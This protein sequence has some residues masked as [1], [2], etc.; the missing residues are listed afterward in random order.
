MAKEQIYNTNVSEFSQGIDL[1]SSP[2]SQK[3][4]T[5][6]FAL[7]AV[8]ETRDGNYNF[9]S[10]ELSNYLT[11]SFSSGFYPIGDRYIGDDTGFVI[12]LNPTTGVVELG[13]LHKSGKWEIIVNT[14]ILGL[15]I[16]NQCDITFRIRK[17]NER[18]VYWTD[19]LNLARV[20]NIDRPENFY[21]TV[22]TDYLNNTGNP[23]TF[24]GERWD[25][26]SFNL[27]KTFSSTP[28]FNSLV[29]LETG[30]I[31]PGSYNFAIQLVDQDL[32][33]TGWIT[34]S[35]TTNVYNDSTSLPYERIRGSRNVTTDSQ[36]FPRT[37]KAIQLTIGNLDQSFPYYRVAII[38][39][40]GNTG[41]P[42]KVLVSELFSTFD[43]IFIYS[44]D[45]ADLTETPL[46][47][48]LIDNTVI[49]APQHIEQLENR[50]IL[51]NGKGKGKNWCDYQRY[52][53]KI[54]ADLT[55]QNV[56]LNN[57]DSQPNVKNASSTFI[58]RG[59]MP[60]ETYS[61]GIVYVHDDGALSPALHIPGKNR[62]DLSANRMKI[63]ELPD[64]YLDI[65]NCSTN[66]YWGVDYLGQTLVGKPIRH[67]RF[68]FR[69]DVNKPLVSST[70]TTTNITRYRLKV[71]IT[72]NPAWTPGPIE[73][74]HDA[75]TPPLP[76]LINYTFNYKVTG[77]GSNSN[78]SGQLTDTDVL[79][80]LDIVLYDDN[81]PLSFVT[82]SVYS[83]LDTSSDLYTIYNP[84]SNNRFIITE[85]YSSYVLSSTFSAD[86]SEIFGV[87]FSNIERPAPDVVGFYIVRN[88]RLDTDRLIIDNALFG[89]T[90]TYQQYVS[91]GLIMPK[92]YYAVN[93]CGRV[94][95]VT[96]TLVYNNKGLWFFNPEYE[97]FGKKLDYDKIEVEGKYTETS[98][99]MPTISDTTN[100]ACNGG[101]GSSG[102]DKG[103]SK[104]IYISDVQAG[105]SFNPDINK[106]KNRDDDGFD[107]VLGYRNTNVS[108]AI[109]NSL[110]LPVKDKVIYLNAATYQNYLGITYYNVSVDNKIGFYTSQATFD[111]N[112]FYNTGNA[113]NALVYGALV[114]N[115][116]TAYSNFIN[117]PYF[118][119]HNN[120]FL[121]GSNN[122]VN[123][124]VFNGDTE[125]SAMNF[126]S[127]VFYDI[128]VAD[129]AKKSSLWKIIVGAVLTVAAIALV[130]LIPPAGLAIGSAV[131]STTAATAIASL[132]ISYG[133]SLAMTGLK[134]DAFKA[135]YEVDYDK[136]LRDTVTDGGVFETIR[137]DIQRDDDTIRWFSDR[138]S[139]LYM[140]SSVPFGLRSG[141]TSGVTD[142]TDSPVAYDEAGFRSYL[143][144]KFTTIDRNQGSGRLY[145]GYAGAEVYD[146]NLDYMRFNKEKE[147]IHLPVEYDC[148]TSET[149]RESHPLR[150]WYS[151]QSFQEE[152]ID[153][154][155]VFLPNNY[156]DIE[157]EHGEITDLYRLG[158]NL[159]I[160]TKEA[161]WQL[162]Q[163]NQERV[164]S[165]LV[166]FI[167]TG[168]FFS[169]PPRKI[170]DDNL[171]SAG[172]QH[173]WSTIKTPIGVFFLS[174]I[175]HKIYV[176]SDKIQDLSIMGIRSYSEENIKSF[177]SKQL[178][179][180]L[181]IEF[182]NRNNPANPNGIGYLAAYDTRFRRVLFTKKDYK[183]VQSKYDILTVTGSIP[184]SGTAFAYCT[185][186]GL[187]YIGAIQVP[188]TNTIYFENKSLTL[189]YSLKSNR[190][191]SWHS[192]LPNYYIFGQNDLYSCI[193]NGIWK[194]H[195]EG[196][197]GNFYGVQYP[198]IIERVAMANPLED[199]TY[200][201]LVLQTTARVWD[202]VNKT[203]IDKRFITF[204]KI[205]LS[206]SRQCSGLLNMIVKDIQANPENWYQQQL[207]NV[208]G[209]ILITRKGRDWNINDFRDYIDDP[210]L[211]LFTSSWDSIKGVYF[212]DKV[213]NDPNI[214]F[215]KNWWELESFRDKYI[216]IRLIFDNFSN[217]NLIVNYSLDTEQISE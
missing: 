6:R 70:P 175:E 42:E 21:S 162:P 65:H 174:E 138:V 77:A 44:G 142:F 23:L 25:A 30:N 171:S 148:C 94:T 106:V 27:V 33:P 203:Y 136:G 127:S 69:K 58:A 170:L 200:E 157:G 185:L 153:N 179:D 74:P 118:K 117:R 132:A 150:N 10:N 145:K 168:E 71:T 212:I 38:R 115:N 172:T 14:L 214:N 186:N 111:T 85:N 8:E 217:V 92:Q 122:I 195:L 113:H 89:P 146:M 90:T 52:A 211:P 5:H 156:R 176:H 184:V 201:D 87:A 193:N 181:G 32:N 130:V 47:D 139:N 16:T 190:W 192:Y 207:V 161:L 96:K 154:F 163:N 140:E 101:N 208:A 206:N 129:R 204:N 210:E 103:G 66:N 37:N 91:F 108:Y 137:S 149:D 205:I 180:K 147:F 4:G 43:S 151:E 107:L 114:K 62:A 45:D 2:L 187:F 105:T 97:Y 7:N 57:I 178:F 100:I 60:G 191:S 110:V 56:L 213:T 215:N 61:F 155:R 88:E 24:I 123:T 116:T 98:V 54:A 18:T 53:S 197:Y 159:F 95:P 55:T 75:G 177:L 82:G 121:F 99:N 112:E 13:L 124:N 84:G 198:Y 39:A 135:M 83:Q 160:H 131:V 119:E 36:T 109:N 165:E 128:V 189:S 48:I 59:Y 68:P 202:S 29:Q 194:H 134:F 19:G 40:A 86:V 26:S 50:L 17:G 64:K 164:T 76:L 183:L 80:P 63:Y 216:V 15:K 11:D 133:V 72:L 196:S 3:K 126:V 34:T 35:N 9:K 12:T 166:S 167:G 209:S 104:G 22:Y 120:P 73:Y 31:L 182:L 81:N 51:A 141:L 188:F 173:K 78:Y 125:I 67:H 20:F 102:T 41:Q 46:E 1:D 144:E 169:I 152:N 49:Y 143:T 158:A 79:T 28:T 199:K 93:N